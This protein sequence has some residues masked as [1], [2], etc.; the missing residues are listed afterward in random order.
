MTLSS[1]PADKLVLLLGAPRSGTTWLAKI[2]DSHPDVV[3]RHEPDTVLRDQRMQNY[4]TSEEIPRFAA[5]GGGGAGQGGR[6]LC[7][8]Y[9][10]R[11]PRFFL[12]FS[13]QLESANYA[14]FV[15][16][17]R[18]IPARE[19]LLAKLTKLA[20]EGAAG[21][22]ADMRIRSSRLELGPPVGYPVQFRVTGPDPAEL[23]RI[24]RE[25]RQVMRA[26]PH[27]RN[28]NDSWG[29]LAKSVQVTVDQDKAR[30]LG[31]SSGD[32]A[33]AL[34]TV[35]TGFAVTD[36]R[37]GTDLIPIVARATDAER[38]DLGNLSQIAIRAP[39]GRTVPLSQIATI[40]YGL[41]EPILYRRNRTPSL[42]VRGDIADGMQAPD[43][44]AQILPALAAIKAKLPAGY[45][46][47]TAGAV[48]ESAKGQASINVIMPLM[49]LV[50]L[51]LLMVQLQSFS[52]VA[53]VLLTAPLGLIGVT[54]ALLVTGAPFGFVAMLGFIALAGI[55]MRNSVILVD[56]IQQDLRRGL[57]PAE[58]IVEAT[59]RRARPIL[60]TAAAAILALVPLAFSVFWG[61]M[62][63]A[64][65]G[66]LVSATLL[67]L[68][69]VPALY[70]AWT[71]VPRTLAT[72]A[73]GR[74]ST[75]AARSKMPVGAS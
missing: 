34:Q 15:I 53:M 36:Y 61:P 57:S 17:T 11:H 48:E 25:V 46:I 12:A 70:A 4:F 3:Y 63:I 14:Q 43:V 51:T 42:S 16:N 44:T 13:P 38:R 54:G 6:L 19:A 39:N 47:E 24:A 30:M 68:F 69:F 66:G 22:F 26:N 65:M 32:V 72:A 27:L 50:M 55:I 33:A 45:H 64:I 23:R 74:D 8:L 31:L 41:E 56:Q 37:E 28:V 75:E 49:V 18:S 73:A 5:R 40:S 21:G 60:L 52:R 20:D 35:L 1:L 59:V 7:R 10:D 2:F 58:A 9:R 62:A 29:N 67:T 71:R